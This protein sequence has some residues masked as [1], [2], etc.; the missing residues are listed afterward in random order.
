MIAMV[1]SSS[2]V[3]GLEGG[4]EFLRHPRKEVVAAVVHEL[5]TVTACARTQ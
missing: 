5:R 3:G 4:L 2:P 1:D